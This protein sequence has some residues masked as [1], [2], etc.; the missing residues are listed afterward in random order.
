MYNWTLVG[1]DGGAT[2]AN[3]RN[4]SKA[5]SAASSSAAVLVALQRSFLPDRA[6]LTFSLTVTNFLDQTGS[7]ELTIKKSAQPAPIAYIQGVNPR[8]TTHSSELVLRLSAWQPQLCEGITL[9]SPTMVFGWGERTGRFSKIG[10]SLSTINPRALTIPAK[11]LLADQKYEFE[12]FVSME[13]DPYINTTTTI[14]VVVESQP[15]AAAISGGHTREV[16]TSIPRQT[17]I[18]KQNKYRSP[19]SFSSK[20]PSPVAHV[21]ASLCIGFVA[22]CSCPFIRAQVGADSVV[23]FSAADSV[24]PDETNSSW[25]FAWS[26]ENVTTP[27]DPLPCFDASGADLDE[28]IGDLDS[29]NFSLAA[30]TLRTNPGYKFSVF[31]SKGVRN[32]TAHQFVIVKPG[33]PPTVQLPGMP[34]DAFVNPN[35]GDDGAYLALQAAADGAVSVQWT[36][37]SGGYVPGTSFAVETDRLTVALALFRMTPGG[38]YT[39]RMTAADAAGESAY[40]ELGVKIN[41]PPTSGTCAV[42]P[43][44]G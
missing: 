29:M 37:E 20:S 33:A 22:I 34:P 17:R 16:R 36:Q 26:C 3:T 30:N 25:H 27:S 32:S 10:G 18:Y 42:L 13:N 23:A 43:A 31:A 35:D 4:I 2:H 1:T 19:G 14:D 5:L 15:I 44:I 21:L 40:G 38:I 24:D 12:A 7:T 39:F 9:S 8:I 28:L 6:K 11:Q 41:S